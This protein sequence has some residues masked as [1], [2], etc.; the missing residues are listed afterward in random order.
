VP[1]RQFCSEL[2]EANGESL[3]ATASRIDHWILVEYRGLWARDEL[4]ASLIPAPAKEHL[5]RQLAALPRARLLFVRRPERRGRDGL[6]LFYGRTR[7]RDPW[8][9]ALELDGYDDLVDLDLTGA[10]AGSVE[11][12][13]EPLGHPLLVVCTHGKRDP[14]CARR[15]RPLYEGL[16]EAADEDWVWQSSHVGGDRFAGNLVCFPEGVYYGRVTRGKALTVLAE[17]L[18][19]RIELEHYRGRCCYSFPVQA[20]E[21]EVRRRTDLRG[22]DDVH[23]EGVER[24]ADSAWR[25]RLRAGPALY[26]VDVAAEHGELTLL[27]CASPTPKSPRRLVVRSAEILRGP[28]A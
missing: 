25:V 4:A 17:H 11:A 27:T 22:V 23:A 24:V 19:G 9:R 14:C 12:P 2:S 28:G 10:L 3:G 15:G 20:A 26:A 6:C 13:G 21:L 18:A 8:F 7:E 5:R 16:R 1:P